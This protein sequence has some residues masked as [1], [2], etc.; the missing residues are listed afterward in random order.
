MEQRLLASLTKAL[1]SS[2]SKAVEA[3][4]DAR[5]TP[6]VADVRA[7]RADLDELRGTGVRTASPHEPAQKPLAAV[8]SS[9]P[10]RPVPTCG[11][12]DLAEELGLQFTPRGGRVLRGRHEIHRDLQGAHERSFSHDDDAHERYF[13]RDG[14]HDHDRR[15]HGDNFDLAYAPRGHGLPHRVVHPYDDDA[16]RERP[17]RRDNAGWYDRRDSL[18]LK[19]FLSGLQRAVSV[20]LDRQ[21]LQLF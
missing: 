2:I 3:A 9:A 21:L 17:V 15:G 14:D 13:R 16:Y 18:H 4:F 6:L 7:L 12:G 1:D 20:T 19:P 10:P 8:T 11:E 5:L